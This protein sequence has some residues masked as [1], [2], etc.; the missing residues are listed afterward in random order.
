MLK[1]SDNPPIRSP[2]VDSLRQLEGTWW[3]AHTKSRFEKAFAWDLLR[4]GIGYFLPLIERVRIS[5]GKKRRVFLPLFASYVF[6]CGDEEVRYATM[7]TDRVCKTIE[8][9]DQ[10]TLV[11]E[12]AAVE[13]ALSSQATLDPYPHTAVGRRCR[14]TAG[15][16]QGID[17][18]VVRRHKLARIVLTVGIL[19]RGAAVEI[20]ADLLESID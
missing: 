20:D 2:G 4:Q 1:P 8:V 6:F 12:L 17:G 13:K 5:G 18:V 10:E 14:I 19:G 7:R 11:A 15:P 3:V 9:A 16:L